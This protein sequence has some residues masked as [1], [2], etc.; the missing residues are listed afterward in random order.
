MNYKEAFD[1]LEI[2]SS[3]VK[4]SD[5]TL[6]LLKKKYHK[7]ALQHHPD[8]ND[9][10][11]ESTEKFKQINEAYTFLKSEIKY[12]NPS[13][14]IEE[15][16]NE[17]DTFTNNSW[18]NILQL[19]MTGIF[20]GKYNE[21]I[22]KII[23]D[24]VLGF[25]DI[26]KNISLKLFQDL[27]KETSMNVYTFLSNYR[28]ILHLSQEMLEEIRGVVLKKYDDVSVYKL[29]PSIHDLINN[30]LYKLYVDDKL[31]LVPLWY[32]EVY[33]ERTELNDNTE[34]LVIC[35]PEL[36]EDIKIDNDN[37][38]CIEIEVQIDEMIRLMKS[39]SNVYIRVGEKEF[40]IPV[41]KLYMKTEQYYRI[42]NQ[43]LT[44]IKNDIYDV[45][46]RADIIVKIMIC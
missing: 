2:D 7:L 43:G 26:K 36:P 12:L 42:K 22:L 32:N 35:E 30:N 8:K 40:S 28:S 3:E 41:N 27:D 5:I 14:F 16:D 10:T 17:S 33:F 39:D 1:I 23:K 29:N 13:D 4:Y 34:I 38:I 25:S 44:K 24:V 31:Y 11:D 45:S 21:I 19:F 18:D 6:K 20:D 37:N 9:N 46:E 15:S